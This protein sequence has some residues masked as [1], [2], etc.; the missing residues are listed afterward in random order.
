MKIGVISTLWSKRDNKHIFDRVASMGLKYV[1]LCCWEPDYLSDE[2]AES[3]IAQ[4]KATGITIASFWAGYSGRVSWNFREGPVNMGIVSPSM[5]W[6]RVK[7]LMKGADFAKKIGAPAIVTH[8][9]FLPENMTDAEYAPVR[10]AITEIAE[11]CKARD[12][13]FWF[14]TGQE[15]PVTLLRY[16]E[17]VGTGNLGINMDT[18]NLIM[19]GKGNPYDA[20]D[21]FGK[22]V[23]SIH[24]KDGLPPTNGKELGAEVQVGT[25]AARYPEL[26][27]KLRRMNYDGAFIIER[28]IEE[29]DEQKKQI[30][31]T[32]ANLHKWWEN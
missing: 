19:Y 20:L 3:V 2:L 12:L 22:Y 21:T 10:S 30:M 7:D 15:T 8:C 14:E 23:T 29:N 6:Q 16:I 24:V 31:E 5:R 9:G 11:Y 1:Q 27:P 4:A 26:M 18:A 32:V 17:D 28:E 13:Q 25:G